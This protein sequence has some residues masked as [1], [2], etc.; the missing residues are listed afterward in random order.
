MLLAQILQTGANFFQ[1]ISEEK[2]DIKVQQKKQTALHI[3][4]KYPSLNN[5][6]LLSL[7]QNV[8]VKNMY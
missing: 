6:Y 5:V 7:V 3:F 1:N 8:P 4:V 2:E